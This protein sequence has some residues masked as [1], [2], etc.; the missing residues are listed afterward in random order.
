MIALFELGNSV[1]KFS[2]CNTNELV[3]VERISYFGNALE[4]DTLLRKSAL[5]WPAIERAYIASVGKKEP[6]LVLTECL[7]AQNVSDLRQVRACASQLGVKNCY[8]NP[9]SLGIDRWLALIAARQLT[10]KNVIIVDAGTALTIDILAADGLHKGGLILP[11]LNM[12][13]DSLLVNTNMD[14]Q[15]NKA[16]ADY[17]LAC[18]SQRAVLNGTLYSIVSS[19]DQILDVVDPKTSG[20]FVRVITGGDA[21]KLLPLLKKHYHYKTNLTLMGLLFV[22]MSEL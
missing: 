19:I 10:N 22:A 6:F 13:R 8:A 16:Q 4:L 15:L 3:A 11:G 2:F 1:L 12:M 14:L 17:E 7:R 18:D 21:E 9:Q 20:D 5:A